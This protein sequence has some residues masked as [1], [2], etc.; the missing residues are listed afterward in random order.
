[1]STYIPPERFEKFEPLFF[2]PEI[3]NR[4]TSKGDVTL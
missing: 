1:M 2:Y 3:K 4:A